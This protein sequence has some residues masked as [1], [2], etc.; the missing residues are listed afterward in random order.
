M[1]SKT[2]CRGAQEQ[3]P[4]CTASKDHNYLKE[5]SQLLVKGINNVCESFQPPTTHG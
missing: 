1:Y 5:N 2:C 4:P 3:S